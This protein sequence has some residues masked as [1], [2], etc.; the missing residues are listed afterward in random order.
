M[1]RSREKAGTVEKARQGSPKSK[2]GEKSRDQASRKIATQQQ[3]AA[4]KLTRAAARKA[5]PKASPRKT[6][7][8]VAPLNSAPP[9]S[10]VYGPRPPRVGGTARRRPGSA[11]RE[12]SG[13]E[14]ESETRTQ[15]IQARGGK[16]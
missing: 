16:L 12:P 14:R 9:L 6:A 11:T 13:R 5:A 8:R 4:K 3:Q 2:L 7:G 15:R 10:A 1:A